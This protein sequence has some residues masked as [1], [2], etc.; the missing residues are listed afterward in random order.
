[1]KAR[2]LL[3]CSV[4]IGLAH[5]AGCHLVFGLD[6]MVI[7]QE[8]GRGGST[9]GGVDGGSSGTGGDAA[10][11]SNG[12]TGGNA[13]VEVV[14]VAAGDRH[15]CAALSNGE[16]YCW[17]VNFD[18]Q[19]GTDPNT[20]PYSTVPVAVSGLLDARYVSVGGISSYGHSCAVLNGN[21]VKCWGSNL[22]GKLGEVGMQS[23]HE[24]VDV[25]N[26]TDVD[27]ITAGGHH[28]CA[29]HKSGTVSCWGLNDYGQL[30][31]DST[32]NSHI[33]VSALGLTGVT[34]ISAGKYHTC[35]MLS[36]LTA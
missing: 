3:W 33:P 9:D 10:G 23:S 31:N 16:G 32:N 13:P 14:S 15:S 6:E 12:G 20:A 35:A 34:D 5:V 27:V 29:L 25:V 24:P 22:Y 26:L 36:D 30:G 11:G 17:G 21:S 1:M 4:G 18:G 28:S 7:G 8:T 2:L 19:I